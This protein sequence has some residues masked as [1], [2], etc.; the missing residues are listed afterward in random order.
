MYVRRMYVCLVSYLVLPCRKCSLTMICRPTRDGMHQD[1]DW[2][3]GEGEHF[4]SVLFG[5]IL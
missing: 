5:M 2:G 4:V 3:A 1:A